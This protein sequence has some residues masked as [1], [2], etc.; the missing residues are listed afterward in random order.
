MQIAP[1][2]ADIRAMLQ[3]EKGI[4]CAG[5]LLHSKLSFLGL[6]TVLGQHYYYIG[7][8]LD[9][10]LVQELLALLVLPKVA[11]DPGL[12][13]GGGVTRHFVAPVPPQFCR[14]WAPTGPGSNYTPP[15]QSCNSRCSASRRPVAQRPPVGLGGSK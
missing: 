7:I 13:M 6:H 3:S 5:A 15:K 14:N 1:V 12:R 4:S 8:V 2:V 9:L 10:L 11:L